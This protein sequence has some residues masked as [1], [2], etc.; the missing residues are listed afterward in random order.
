MFL[1]GFEP[2]PEGI[3]TVFRTLVVRYFWLFS[4]FLMTACAHICCCDVSLKFKKRS[5]VFARICG[6]QKGPKRK[7]PN[8]RERKK[9]FRLLNMH[10][11]LP[12][13]N[14]VFPF[15]R[16][17][18][19][20]KNVF[21]HLQL[22]SFETASLWIFNQKKSNRKNFIFFLREFIGR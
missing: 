20:R 15:L 17:S 8:E 12:F 14:S 2:S 7:T 9:Y 5:I 4:V 1:M 18:F 10:L 16:S 22:E 19:L 3:S 21:T 11:L 13:W 6:Y